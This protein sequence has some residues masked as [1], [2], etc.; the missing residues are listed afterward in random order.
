MC[1]RYIYE[2]HSLFVIQISIQPSEVQLFRKIATYICI[3]IE[4]ANES[5]KIYEILRHDLHWYKYIG[6]KTF[7]LSCALV[8]FQDALLQKIAENYVADDN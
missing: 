3:Y 5:I 7:Q 8:N 6:T 4:R 2:Y 1:R